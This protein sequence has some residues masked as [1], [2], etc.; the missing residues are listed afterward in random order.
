MNKIRHPAKYSDSLLPVFSELLKTSELVLDPFAGTGKLREVRPDAILLEIEPEWAKINNALI[1]NA[2]AMPEEWS[3]KFDAVCTSPTYGNRLADHHNAK[4]GSRR[5][6]YTHC[7]GRPLSPDNSGVLQ[8]GERYRDF[9]TKVWKEVYRVLKPNGLFILNISN[10]IRQKQI[11]NVAEWHKET[12]LKLGFIF[13]SDT[14]VKTPRLRYGKN[15]HL[16][17]D[18]EHVFCF[19]KPLTVLT[20]GA[21]QE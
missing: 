2:L 5:N 21:K 11:V 3:S 7:L 1:G 13:L 19:Q 14:L 9:H 6:S 15:S 17:V 12:I 10:H 18:F 8:W 20:Q 4:D 16:R